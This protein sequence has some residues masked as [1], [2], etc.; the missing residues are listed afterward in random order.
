MNERETIKSYNK[1]GEIRPDKKKKKMKKKSAIRLGACVWTLVVLIILLKKIINDTEHRYYF[2]ELLI[3]GR[4][5]R[6]A[7]PAWRWVHVTRVLNCATEQRYSVA[8]RS[9]EMRS[10]QDS[11]GRLPVG[12]ILAT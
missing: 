5:P 11:A 10:F 1:A 2:S 12:N 8:F 9:V 4:G 6:S 7:G 3:A